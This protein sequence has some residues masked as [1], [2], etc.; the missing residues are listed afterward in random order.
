MPAKRIQVSGDNGVTYFTLPGNQGDLKD[1]T[2]QIEDTIFGQLF[3]SAE[4]GLINAQIS[5]NAIYKG[6]A[7]YTCKIYKP[8]VSTVFTTEACTLVSGKTYQ[9]NDQTKRMWDRLG[10]PF[11]FF[12]NAINRNTEVLSVDYLHGRVTFKPTYTVIGPVTI[13]G[14]FFPRVQLA[15]Y[16]GFT[17]GMQLDAID[18]TDIPTTQVNGGHMLYNGEGLKTVS[19][20]LNGVYNATNAFRA[21]LIARSEIILEVNPDGSNQSI[22]RGFFKYGSRGQSGNIGALEEETLSA[23]L[24]VPDS[25]LMETPFSWN[26]LATT[27]LNQGIQQSII[28]WQNGTAVKVRYLPDGLT[29]FQFDAIV[30]DLSLTGGMEKMNEFS[31]QYQCTGAATVI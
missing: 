15:A 20:E 31:V 17:L 9:I 25:A 29:G 11:N 26:H 18:I 30:T 3:K 7:G 1:E 6:F 8:G 10:T 23:R 19:L 22:A 4:V 24:F 27:T 5:S 16:R 12:D 2:G 28:A 13:T 21:A 14:R